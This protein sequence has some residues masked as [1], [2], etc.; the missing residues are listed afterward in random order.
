MIGITDFVNFLLE[1]IAVTKMS[2]E[3]F[4]KA[5]SIIPTSAATDILSCP[6]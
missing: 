2:F 1:D 3:H 4:T 5:V 6:P